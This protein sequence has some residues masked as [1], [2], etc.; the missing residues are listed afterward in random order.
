MFRG[1]SWDRTSDTRIFSPLLYRLS[2]D[3]PF[4][5]RF[6]NVAFF[7]VFQ[8]HFFA[9]T[10]NFWLLPFGL[11]EFQLIRW[12]IFFLI[13]CTVLLV[14]LFKQILSLKHLVNIYLYIKSNSYFSFKLLCTHNILYDWTGYIYHHFIGGCLPVR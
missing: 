11:V 5:L 4:R 1:I 12:R 6:A 3:T 10:F 9:F 7:F 8:K 14:L 2:Y 13:F